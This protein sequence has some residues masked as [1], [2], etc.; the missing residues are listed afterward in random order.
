MDKPIAAESARWGDY[1]RDVH[2]YQDGLYVLYTRENQW[3]AENTRLVNIYFPGRPATLLTQLRAAGLYPSVA[4]PEYR[5]DT[6]SG[7]LV[8]SSR[9]SAGFVLAMNNPGATGTIYYTTDGN[10]PHIYYTPT[11]GATGSSTAA[12]AQTYTAPLTINLT[13]T[14][15]SRILSN[16]TWSAL[17]EATLAVGIPVVPIAITEIMYDPPNSAHEFVELQN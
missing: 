3:L 8:G 2:Q 16:G 1:R 9:V 14:I 13:T 6:T 15:K 12:T 4:A 10:D 7:G 11:T 5:Q 17:N